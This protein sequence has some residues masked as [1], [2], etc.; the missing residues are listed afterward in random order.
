MRR[1][2]RVKAIKKED[3]PIC[4][5][6]KNLDF[7]NFEALRSFMT[8]RGK[9]MERT[10]TGICPKHQKQASVAIKRA[11]FLALLPFAV[12]A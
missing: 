3:C 9:I 10:R 1:S 4:K 6:G 11:R 5:E 8:E 12:R 7:R 2:K